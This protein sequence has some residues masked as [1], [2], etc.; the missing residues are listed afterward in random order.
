LAAQKDGE[1]GEAHADEQVLQE[2][3]EH[4]RFNGG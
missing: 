1:R 4:E 2:L 3:R